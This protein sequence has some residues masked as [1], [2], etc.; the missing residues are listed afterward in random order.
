LHGWYKP[1]RGLSKL[2]CF[3][4]R[5]ALDARVNDDND[6]IAFERV[7]ADF[8]RLPY[9][10]GISY[11]LGG[12]TFAKTTTPGYMAASN[13]TSRA[14][15]RLA[16]RGLVTVER[17]ELDQGRMIAPTSQGYA[18]AALIEL[19]TPGAFGFDAIDRRRLNEIIKE[20]TQLSREERFFERDLEI[21]RLR[22]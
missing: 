17:Y 20:S 1:V 7:K 14:A 12:W 18:V 22:G 9:G 10:S 16:A 11:R 8:F 3:I 5:A 4:L 15:G 2:Q 13:S 21:F 6:V 19:K